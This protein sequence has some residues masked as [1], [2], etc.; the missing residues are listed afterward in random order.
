MTV[1]KSLSKICEM[2]D[3]ITSDTAVP[4]N[5]RRAVSEAKSRLEG[6][7]EL[8]VKIS[9]AIYLIESVSDDVNMPPH[10]RSQIWAILGA[11]ESIKK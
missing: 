6:T 8:S 5:I 3:D 7:E 4:K 2:M 9:A 10:T 1:E 11:L